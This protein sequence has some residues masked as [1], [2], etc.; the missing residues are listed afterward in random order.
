MSWQRGDRHARRRTVRVAVLVIATASVATAVVVAALLL[1][2]PESDI[3]TAQST[4]SPCTSSRVVDQSLGALVADCQ[5][6]WAI[7]AREGLDDIVGVEGT[8]NDPTFDPTGAWGHTNQLHRW[9]GVIVSEGRV[10][11]L[12]LH[13]ISPDSWPDL[14][15]LTGLRGL[16]VYCVSGS[17][18]R[19]LA[20]LESLERLTMGS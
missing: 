12:T 14:L 9:Y 15:A 13:G 11:D 2:E 16:S 1:V 10:I 20:D 5:A 19:E 18:P 6:L 17:I 7:H 4:H 8:A 3:G